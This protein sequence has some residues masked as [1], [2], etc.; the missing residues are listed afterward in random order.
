[1]GNVTS[2]SGYWSPV[3]LTSTYDQMN[4]VTA[5][6]STSN[7]TTTFSY[8][9]G[10]TGNR[11]MAS[12]RNGSS[13]YTYDSIYRMTEEAISRSEA[14]GTLT[15]GLD[16]VGNRQSL[17]STVTGINQQSASYN[18]NDQAL[19]NTYDAN[20]NTLGANGKSYAYDSFDRMTSFNGGSVTMVYDG[21]GNRVKKISG[22]VTTQYLVDELNPTGL[23]Q[24]MDEVVKSGVAQ[25]TYLYGLRRI[26]QTQVAS[27]T[28]SYYGYDA[29]GDV[30][31]LMNNG[32][33]VTDTY[34]YDAFGSVVG[35]TGTT[36][37][38]YRY[39]G[40]ALD[41]ETG[42]YYLRARY[43]DPTVGRFL[44]VDPMADQGEHPYEY[45]DADP[46]DGHDP[47]GEQDVIETSLLMWLYT[48][49][50]PPPRGQITCW[51][52][53]IYSGGSAGAVLDAIMG[54]CKSSPPPR[55]GPPP[56]PPTPDKPKCCEKALRDDV[57]NFLH[58]QAPKLVGWDPN[59]VDEFMSDGKGINVDPRLMA[60]IPALESGNGRKFQGN[61]PF[62]LGPGMKFNSP[63]VAVLAYRAALDMHINA[64]GQTSVALLYAGNGNVC[65]SAGCWPPSTVRMRTAYCYGATP[66][67][68]A[69][70][71]A[72]GETIAGFLS[73]MPGDQAND[74]RPGDPNN[75]TYPCANS[76]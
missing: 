61:N 56:K 7:P 55:P 32:G 5:L 64:W 76:K 68:R 47:T 19:A 4:R 41:S 16:P 66:E 8:A 23:P 10:K 71:Q 31:S 57:T 69:E 2:E 67:G 62:N 53:I 15:Y 36:P 13:N 65:T 75:L 35:S 43:Y 45:A 25:R 30:R 59:M 14:K 51:D 54:Q 22:G 39:Q 58:D 24:V 49:H 63:A 38:V 70:C 21:D 17:A 74:L 27:G 11:L 29:H 44:N 33:V 20:G 40:E 72:A 50:V 48:A 73:G 52:S 9:Y 3:T 34:D 18:V 28:T 26:S 6:Q 37:N 42:L 1:V 46:V 12:D 60:A